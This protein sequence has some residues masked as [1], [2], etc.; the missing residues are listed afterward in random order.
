MNGRLQKGGVPE[1]W[2]VIGVWGRWVMAIIVVR[3][4][5]AVL[6]VDMVIRMNVARNNNWKATA[7]ESS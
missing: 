1:G 5:W 3:M 4:E 2:D 7:I 6:M